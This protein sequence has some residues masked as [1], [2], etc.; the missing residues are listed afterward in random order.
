[1]G[2]AGQSRVSADKKFTKTS[3]KTYAGRSEAPSQIP[4]KGLET[5]I[6]EFRR[7]MTQRGSHYA[8]AA[9]SGFHRRCSSSKHPIGRCGPRKTQ[10]CFL[11]SKGGLRDG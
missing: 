4:G 1:M 10:R 2:D 3:E 8:G 6:P 11:Q 9:I 7:G 5:G